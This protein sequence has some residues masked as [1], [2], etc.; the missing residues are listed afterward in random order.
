MNNEVTQMQQM[1]GTDNPQAAQNS[2]IGA[3]DASQFQQS[4][5]QDVLSQNRELQVVSTGKPNDPTK[6]SGLTASAVV[7]VIVSTIVLVFIASAVFKWV[8]K[9]PEAAEPSRE[10][11]TPKSVAKNEKKATNTPASKSKSVKKSSSK[12]KKKSARAKRKK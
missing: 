9:R 4:A 1:S 6:E 12:V 2:S 3:N 10:E 11:P 5:G 7:F 8:M